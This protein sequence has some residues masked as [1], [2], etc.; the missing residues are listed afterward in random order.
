MYEKQ[1]PEPALGQAQE[2]P[3]VRAVEQHLRDRQTNQL[4]IGD[5]RRPAK[6]PSGRQEIIN[7]HVNVRQQGVEVGGHS[8][9]LG[10]R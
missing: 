5:P 4:A 7:E 9:L 2:A 1:M 6:P 3:L 10:R 8:G